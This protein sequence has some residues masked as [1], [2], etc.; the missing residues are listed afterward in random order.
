MTNCIVAG[1]GIAGLATAHA[2]LQTGSAVTLLERG[3]IGQESS[4]AGGG[5]LSPLCPWDYPDA[6]TRLTQR[7]AALFPA[8]A[9]ALHAAT[10]IDPEYEVSGM[11]VL[12]PFD[13]EAAQRWCAE[14]GVRLEENLTLSPSP[15]ALSRPP[16][17]LT[18]VGVGEGG[19]EGDALF[20][21]D[22]AQVRT[23]RLLRALRTRVEQLGGR[24]VEQCDVRSLVTDHGRVQALATS[25][26][27][28]RA[29][30]FVVTAGAWSTQVLGQHALQL[31]IKPVRGQML[32]FK[33][34]SP[35]L[36]HIVLQRDLYLIPR[37]DGHLLVGSTL[38][39]AGFDKNVTQAACDDLHQRAEVLLPALHGMQP[40]QHWA[41]LRPASPH[42]IPTIGRHPQLKNLYL[43]S[44]HFRYGITMA[45]ASAEILLNEIT[46]APQPLDVAPYQA[47]WNN[48]APGKIALP[49]RSAYNPAGLLM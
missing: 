33:F 22:A 6:V 31:D 11:L 35:P 8:W 48:T 18:G 44:G 17:P 27:E 10:G 49:S 15:S 37:R 7:G 14:H 40:V 46:G 1:G 30:N 9:Q 3:A 42:N 12:P 32:L 43:N 39:D 13:A 34:A 38:E 26:G 23:P 4:W 47:G 41:G 36:R 21:P 28:F 16:L 24:I 19:G 2:L 5:I 20:L 45:P 29:E 25:C